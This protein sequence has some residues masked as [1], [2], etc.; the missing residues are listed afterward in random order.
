M[1]KGVGFVAF[2]YLARTLGPEAYGATELAFSLA[3]LF[4]FLVEF[5]TDAIGAREV[6]R[7]RDA[8]PRLAAQIPAMRI[9]VALLAIPLMGLAV[10]AM[11]Q[12]AESVRL[13]W[14]FALGLLAAPWKQGWLL[15]GLEMMGWVSASGAIRMGVF[16][17][18]VLLL[19]RGPEDL[20]LVGAA[21]LAAALCF[22][23]YFAVVQ[24]RR[25]TPLRLSFAPGPL[26]RLL[27]Q[28]LPLGLTQVVWSATQYL[29]TMLVATFIGG[30]AIA[31]FAAAHRIVMSVW[32]FSWLYHFNLFPA[33]TRN[34][35][36]S[37]EAFYALVRPS[38]R[39]CAWVGFGAALVGGVLGEPLC[40]LVFGAPFAA[41]G[42]SLSVLVWILPA[43][44]LS[45]HARS[46][47][48]ATGYQRF[49]LYAQSI[50]AVVMLVLGGLLV[51]EKGALG[52][53]IAMAVSSWVV[54]G[55]SHAAAVQLVAP[56]SLLDPLLRPVLATA[57]SFLVVYALDLPPWWDAAAAASCY[58]ACAL[59]AD[60]RLLPDL[61]RVAGAKGPAGG[62]Q[63][64]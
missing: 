33:V 7:D 38:L 12:P 56:L 4:G 47:L 3:L 28:G 57:A 19:V 6:A 9:L 1:G 64:P 10:A 36:E 24:Q 52:G 26:L 60:R 18:G 46:A 58:T 61:R 21:E 20:L 13:V 44:L 55:V 54:F 40:R 2:A 34:L 43:T 51:P 50:G 15:Q 23:V 11:G 8:V 37:R 42:D 63:T 22:A 45:G 35:A 49:V 14:L 59:L 17:L 5:G 30:A 48:I 62:G 41:A 53:S 31:W 25:V 27:R 32:T 29:P 39:A 16:A